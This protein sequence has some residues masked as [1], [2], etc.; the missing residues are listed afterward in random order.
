[1]SRRILQLWLAMGNFCHS[2]QDT[3]GP[4]SE[5][6]SHPPSP[7]RSPVPSMQNTVAEFRDSGSFAAAVD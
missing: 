1:V 3:L 5:P 6:G 2:A 7:E 4:L